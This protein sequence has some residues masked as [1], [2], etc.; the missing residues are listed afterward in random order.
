[1]ADARVPDQEIPPQARIVRRVVAGVL[2]AATVASI[3]LVAIGED[4]D[5]PHPEV[6]EPIARDAGLL[7]ERRGVEMRPTR[8]PPAAQVTPSPPPPPP[9]RERSPEPAG[10]DLFH[11]GA[12]PIKIG[13][14][15]PADFVLPPGYL[16]HVQVTD[17]GVILEPIL[18]FDPDHP[19]KDDDGR[20]IPIT[21]DRVVPAESAPKGMPIRVL[22]SP[23]DDA[24][25]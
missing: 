4:E 12:K 24:D 16:R 15:V 19:P 18:M 20:S 9:P 1:M 22:V 23:N 3:A 11:P 17:D 8:P 21:P 25:R 14:V 2:L 13:I 5:E 6:T 10:I 7:F